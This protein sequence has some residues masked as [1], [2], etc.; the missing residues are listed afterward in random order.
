MSKKL[1]V[2]ADDFGLSEAYD[3]GAAKA[4][5]EG[6]ASV[7]SLIVSTDEAPR[8]V[9]LRNRRCPE[10]QLALHVNYCAG[11]PVSDPADIPSLVDERGLFHR[12]SEWVQGP[13]GDPKCQGSVSPTFEDLLREMRAQVCRYEEL[14]GAPPRRVEAHSVMTEEMLRAFAEVGD[15]LGVHN[16][17]IQG[18]ESP[19]LRSCGECVP[20][21]GRAA[22]LA[23][24]ARGCTPED[25]ESDAFGILGCPYEIAILHFHP[26]YVDQRVVDCSS[27]VLARCRDLQTL[28]DP[29]VWAWV[30]ANGIDLVDYDAVYRD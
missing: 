29:R 14:V 3:L 11:R 6:V 23:L 27:L 25:W 20:E 10:A 18:E 30:E 19:T 24:V 15:E 7:L 9:E 5:R 2:S 1:I 21:G 28:T 12:S 4:Y 13:M 16:E 8:A 26:G 22:K 17:S